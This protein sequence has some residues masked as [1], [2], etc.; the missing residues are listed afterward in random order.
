MRE[1]W[2]W[3]LWLIVN[4]VLF[5][6]EQIIR[7]SLSRSALF[8]C[9][10]A[11]KASTCSCLS[12]NWICPVL[13]HGWVNHLIA[14]SRWLSH[15]DSLLC[16]DPFFCSSFSIRCPIF[17]C[18]PQVLVFPA[19][20]PFLAWIY[21][22]PL[23]EVSVSVCSPHDRLCFP[24]GWVFRLHFCLLLRFERRW[25]FS[26]PERSAGLGLVHKASN[27]CCQKSCARAPFLLCSGIRM[28]RSSRSLFAGFLSPLVCIPS[29][30]FP[31]RL[32]S[33]PG[34]TRPEV[35][36]LSCHSKAIRLWLGASILVAVLWFLLCCDACR[37]LSVLFLSYRI[38]KLEVF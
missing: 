23:H 15:E 18:C 35:S 30:H 22:F 33:A 5:L 13:V 29:K 10:C 8:P 12:A 38:K 34:A 25:W 1:E 2:W 26:R 17:G 14:A 24:D 28:S 20:G 16:F 6:M 37:W 4:L 21:R 32:S 9:V 31:L 36:S 3:P 11:M 7:F 27:S 19:A